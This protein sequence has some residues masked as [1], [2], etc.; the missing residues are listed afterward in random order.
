LFFARPVQQRSEHCKQL[1]E[2]RCEN[3]LDRKIAGPSMGKKQGDARRR[4]KR[5]K[6]SRLA[7]SKME[8]AESGPD[9]DGAFD[10]EAK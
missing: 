1:N 3:A 5:A 4:Q 2:N 8:G 9:Q 10:R 7:Q 6:N